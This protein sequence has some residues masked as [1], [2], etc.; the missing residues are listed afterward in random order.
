M[1]VEECILVI[2]RQYLVQTGRIYGHIEVCPTQ[3]VWQANLKAEHTG[4]T[5]DRIGDE[6]LSKKDKARLG[7]I[8]EWER[9]VP[10]PGGNPGAN[11][12][13]RKSTPIQMPRRRGGIC[14]RLS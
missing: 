14:G 6:T 1:K 12:W 13:F 5:A 9:L 4:A 7:D 11:G 8:A 3:K 10:N 2:V